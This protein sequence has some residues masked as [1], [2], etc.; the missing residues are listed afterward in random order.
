[1][2]NFTTWA[3][4]WNVP[5]AALAELYASVLPASYNHGATTSEA[6][7]QAAVR[8]RAAELGWRLWRNNSGVLSGEDGR[9]VRFGLGNDSKQ[10][11]NIFKSADLIGVKPSGQFV[12]LECKAAGWTYHGTERER[13]Q[14]AFLSVVVMHGGDGRFITDAGQL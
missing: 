6:R 11:N 3:Q 4:R 14:A 2:D 13:A 10:I 1:M 8:V 12:A 7:V 9:P 5:P